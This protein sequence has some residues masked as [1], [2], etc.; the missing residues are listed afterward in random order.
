MRNRTPVP[1]LGPGSGASREMRDNAKVHG[2]SPPER[3]RFE[4]FT[5]DLASRT[6][7]DASGK[8]V[9]LW[10]SEFALLAAFLRASGRVLSREQLLDA[11]SGRRAEAFDRSIDVLVGRLRRKIELDPK[12]PRL[13]TTVQGVGYKFTARPHVP[14]APAADAEPEAQPSAEVPPRRPAERRHLT[15]LHCAIA[16]AGALAHV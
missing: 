1:V 9:P 11:V 5:L 15:V 14:P 2:D 16:S 3:W 8:E 10:R 7:I 4:G 6:L 12:A 13:I